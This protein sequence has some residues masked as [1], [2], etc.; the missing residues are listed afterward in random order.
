MVLVRH[1]SVFD[2]VERPPTS[3]GS[4]FYFKIIIMVETKILDT[5]HRVFLAIPV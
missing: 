3:S 1:A 2:R 5:F 4:R